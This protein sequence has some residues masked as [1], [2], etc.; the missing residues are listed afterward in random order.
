MDKDFAF[1]TGL[2]TVI[3]IVIIV[4]IVV[5][6][7]AIALINIEPDYATLARKVD[8]CVASEHF[9]REECILILAD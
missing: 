9:T 4:V 7:L 6:V 1:L 8:S 5:A 2:I 3:V